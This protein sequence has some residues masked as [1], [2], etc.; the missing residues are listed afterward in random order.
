[1]TNPNKYGAYYI[2]AVTFLIDK[3]EKGYVNNCSDRG[4]ETKY[5]ISKK[6][7]HNTDI[8]NLTKAKAIDLYY[9]R[10]WL[11][12]KCDKFE[13][14]LA[15]ILFDGAVHSGPR[16][17]IRW[18]QRSLNNLG[19]QLQVDG[20]LGD[21]TTAEVYNYPIDAIISGIIAEREKFLYRLCMRKKDQRAN[22]L[23]WLDRMANIVI[24]VNRNSPDGIE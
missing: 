5:G 15:Y 18:L 22:L 10:Y 19:A 8:A 11:K 14:K 17:S 4:G 1:M 24:H 20:K 2:K 12:T 7:F 13:Y 6:S 16:N 3:I 9:K 21:K 23:G